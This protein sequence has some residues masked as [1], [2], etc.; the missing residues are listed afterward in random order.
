[1][2]IIENGTVATP[3]G[4]TATAVPA[5]IK[6]PDR[7]DLALIVSEQDCAAAGVFTQNQVAAAPVLVDKE[8]LRGNNGR[9]R[10]VVAN[11]G[12]ANACTGKRGLSDAR[13]TQVAAAFTLDC[14]FSQVLLLSTGVIGVPLPME[15]LQA[16]VQAAAGNLKQSAAEGGLW[17]ARAIMTTDTH[18][19]H[20]AVQVELAQGAVT[21]GGMAKGA[22][23]IHPNMATMLGVLTT[24]A[25]VSPET[26]QTML[27]QAVDAS[28][29]RIS[30]DG[31]TSTN[32]TVLLLAN[33]ASG[34]AVTGESDHA[35]FLE[36]LLHICTQLA[37][38]IVR[39]G[40]GATKFA[41]IHVTGAA[42]AADAHAIA[43][44][45]A[46][47]PLVKTA[48]AGSDANWGRI[49]AAAGRAGVTFDQQQVA[50]WVSN[51]GG[52][53]LQ[54]VAAGMPTAY[55]EADAAAIFAYSEI[56]IHLDIHTGTAESTVW[57]TDLTHDY[58]TIN[59]DYRT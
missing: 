59:A 56:D 18:P 43:N 38:M 3:L 31:D 44:T 30:V 16:G 1:M 23:M 54:L 26:L 29:N 20:L 49:L 12:N 53:S 8:T 47:S 37:Q 9:I 13:L 28:F 25:A 39:D 15:K 19:K 40:E 17:A 35:A 10:A 42:T 46:T 51:P 41:A 32:D 55:A 52:E 6:Y 50:L 27:K 7:L 33:G 2:K 58:V 36:G 57:T 45:I 4:F 48:L 21:I 22:G 24:D 14:E 34:T 11:A 5:H